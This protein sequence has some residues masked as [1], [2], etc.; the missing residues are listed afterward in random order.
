MK[1]AR[2]GKQAAHAIDPPADI[3]FIPGNSFGVRAGIKIYF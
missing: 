3:R 2:P 1:D